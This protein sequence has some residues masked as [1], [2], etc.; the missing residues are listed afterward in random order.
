ML[1][2]SANLGKEEKSDIL[3]SADLGDHTTTTLTWKAALPAGTKVQLSLEDAN[4]D[5]AW[6]GTVSSLDHSD[7]SQLMASLDHC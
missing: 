7:G 4:G 6:S 3:C 2:T 5:E 1:C